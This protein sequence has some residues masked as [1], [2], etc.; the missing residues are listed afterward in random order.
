MG[1][2]DIRSPSELQGRRRDAI[3]AFRKRKT[4]YSAICDNHGNQTGGGIERRQNIDLVTRA[5]AAGH[6]AAIEI[7]V[8]RLTVHGHADIPDFRR[9]LPGSEFGRATPVD[10]SRRRC[11]WNEI[12]PLDH[13]PRI[14]RDARALGFGGGAGEL[15]YSFTRMLVVLEAGVPSTDLSGIV[16]QIMNNTGPSINSVVTADGFP[17]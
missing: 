2:R 3:Q 9:K 11:R 7:N 14:L 16:A 6:R 13:D 8:S 4:R 1:R 5:H 10:S 12:R 17:R 15:C